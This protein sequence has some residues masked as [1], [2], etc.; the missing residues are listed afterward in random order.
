MDE[1]KGLSLIDQCHV[2][3][4]KISFILDKESIP[5]Q[6]L[7]SA[8]LLDGAIG[9]SLKNKKPDEVKD[10]ILDLVSS[11]RQ[12]INA[13][14]EACNDMRPLHDRMLINNKWLEE[15][16]ACQEGI[17]WFNAHKL[18]S[19]DIDRLVKL[20]LDDDHDKWANWLIT[21]VLHR[22]N[23]VRYAIYAAR[24]VLYIY[25]NEYP[26]DPRPKEAIEAA[27]RYLDANG[28]TEIK[29][30]RNAAYAAANAAAANAAY[31]AYAAANAAYAAYVAAYA[32]N[33]ANAA[34]NFA[35]A[36]ADANYASAHSKRD[37]IKYGLKLIKEQEE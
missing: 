16:G 6:Q 17:D 11:L 15:K 12:F 7:A 24:S 29:G 26:N 20:L 18:I 37:I 32:A 8:I 25:E 5:I 34:A 10:D 35:Y 1:E 31:A 28:S 36:A 9:N 30:V 2:V 22:D 21:H 33:A 13:G 3:C 27:E 4:N 19:I 23:N 14:Y